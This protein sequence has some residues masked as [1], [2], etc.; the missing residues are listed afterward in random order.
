MTYMNLIYLGIITDRVPIIAMFTPSHIGGD[1]PVITFGEVFDIPRFIEE[2][3]TPLL[4]WLDVKDPDSEVTDTLGCWNVWEA[5]QSYE[6][7]AREGWVPM[8]LNLG[9][10]PSSFR[11]C[12]DL[13]R[14]RSRRLVH[15][16]AQFCEADP[17]L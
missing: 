10:F 14:H 4:E 17:R 16:G 1:A 12:A 7:H 2:T 13:L 15:Q 9:E 6:T 3:G 11:V 8:W 5:V